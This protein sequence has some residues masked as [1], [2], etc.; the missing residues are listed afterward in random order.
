MNGAATDG[1]ARGHPQS[2]VR[3][4]SSALSSSRSA[5]AQGNDHNRADE[6]D[7]SEMMATPR[8]ST[9]LTQ[10]IH[11]KGT[12]YSCNGTRDNN[13]AFDQSE[14]GIRSAANQRHEYRDAVNY[15][16]PLAPVI[17]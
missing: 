2:F 10:S 5:S 8:R 12:P 3:S 6:N 17:S 13:A 9:S 1:F 14:Q 4:S 15:M 7:W 11:P 16:I